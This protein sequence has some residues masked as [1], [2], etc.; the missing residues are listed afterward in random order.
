[1]TT[2]DLFVFLSCF[3]SRFAQRQQRGRLQRQVVKIKNSSEI[4]KFKRHRHCCVLRF[5]DLY[6]VL[7]IKEEML[8]FVGTK[9]RILNL[10]TRLFKVDPDPGFI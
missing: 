3:A 4:T 8:Q 9:I 1:M 7:E 2:S 10:A 5:I 6:C